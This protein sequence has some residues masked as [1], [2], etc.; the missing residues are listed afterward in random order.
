MAGPRT[1]VFDLGEVL[2]PSTGVLPVLADELG[3]SEAALAAAYWPPRRAY[4]LGGDPDA[5]W[6]AVLAALG[7]PPEPAV[8]ATLRRQDS[9]RWSA[10]P[11]QSRQLLATLAGTR[12]GVLS[13]AP[14][15]L[16]ASVRAA[17][18]SRAVDVLVFSAD[19]GLA[20][21]DPRIYTRADAAYGTDP[22]QV[23][24]F[25]DRPDNVA[26]ARDHGWDAHVWAG[27]DAALSVL[28]R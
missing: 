9:A 13:N 6:A 7:R 16:A 20:K 28:A 8:L 27:P 2:V 14:A 21:P 10:L 11:R 15:P 24:F 1:V 23:I 5:Y 22:G 12:L 4:D 18:W 3:V 17:P 19:V 25:D 26:A